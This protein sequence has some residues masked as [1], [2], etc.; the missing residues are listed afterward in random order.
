MIEFEWDI[1]SLTVYGIQMNN[2]E[3]HMVRELYVSSMTD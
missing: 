2:G 1:P 3:F